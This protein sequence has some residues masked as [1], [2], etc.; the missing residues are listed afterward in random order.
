MDEI[1]G[2]YSVYIILSN[3]KG[4][5]NH[6]IKKNDSERSSIYIDDYSN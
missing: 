1:Q 6:C 3:F 4:I 5:T 2:E